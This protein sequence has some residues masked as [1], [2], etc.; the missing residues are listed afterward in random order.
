MSVF[1]SDRKYGTDKYVKFTYFE[2]PQFS[3]KSFNVLF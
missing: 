2:I 1:H 3:T